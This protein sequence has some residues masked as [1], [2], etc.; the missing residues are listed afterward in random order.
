MEPMLASALPWM[1]GGFALLLLVFGL[2]AWLASRYKRCPPDRVLVVYGRTGAKKTGASSSCYHGGGAFVWPIIQSCQ[3]LD[4]TPMPIDIRLEGALSQQ[5]IRVNTPST[6]TVG[7]STEPG[8]MQNA[9]ERLLG[10]S[11]PQVQELAKDIIFGQMRVVI[12]TM[13][14]EEINADRDK[15]IENISDGVE[16]ELKK[17][18]LRL[19]NVNIQDITD[20]SGYIDALGQEAAARAINEAKIKVA[21]QERDGE[22]G[23][24]KAEQSRR[25]EVAAAQATATEG[26]NEAKV[27]VAQSDAMR[28]EAEAEAERKGSAAERVK[29]AAVQQEAYAAEEMAE[30]ER[31]KREQATQYANV[32]VP[33][34]IEQQRIATLAEAEAEKTRRERK[35]EA[36][37]IRSVM[38]AE[39][40]GVQAQLSAKADGFRQLIEST[41]DNYDFASLMMVIEQLPELIAEQVKAVSNLK[42][43][44]VTVWDSGSNGKDSGGA[45]SDF[46]SGLVK[47]I[48]PLQELTKNVGV[49]L[50]D[51]LGTMN[52]PRETIEVKPEPEPAMAVA[53]N[54]FPRVEAPAAA[55]A[56][57]RVEGGTPPPVPE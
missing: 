3:F 26:E 46:L 1:G 16:V 47:S 29:S 9:A 33:A 20:E 21:Q 24:A 44:K 56:E 8:V 27:T 6:F 12:A 4:L 39:A 51:F 25:I 38:E 14:I 42:I 36:D 52:G 15:M 32:V 22:I 48:P 10:L 54:P 5:N 40:A 31:A 7:V 13:P 41:N 43:D 53:E 34:E 49:K 28:R 19:I 45:T 23:K 11:Q 30:R 37:G 55:P 57:P 35:G 18:G 2:I 50:P 17:V